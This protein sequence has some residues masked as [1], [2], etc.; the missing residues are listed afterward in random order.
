MG[1]RSESLRKR[2]GRLRAKDLSHRPYIHFP[3][4]ALGD[5]GHSCAGSCEKP[6]HPTQAELRLPDFPPAPFLMLAQNTPPFPT[7]S[8]RRAGHPQLPGKAG[9]AHACACPRLSPRRS[10][11][12]A[13]PRPGHRPRCHR[14]SCSLKRAFLISQ[15]AGLLQEGACHAPGRMLLAEEGYFCPTWSSPVQS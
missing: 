11:L 10:S 12:P 5:T 4:C 1:E 15:T 3:P 9:G 13:S 14:G 8:L 6:P 7:A 2:R